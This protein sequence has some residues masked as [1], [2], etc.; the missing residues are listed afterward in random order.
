MLPPQRMALVPPF[1]MTD[2]EVRTLLSPLRNSISVALYSHGNPF[3][4]GAIIRVA[5][6]FLVR[7]IYIVGREPSYAKGSMGMHR[8]ETIR[9]MDD[10]EAFL[11]AVGSRPLWAVEKDHAT[12]SLFDDEPF[13]HDVVLLFGSERA[14]LPAGMLARAQQVL[15]V[16]M[17]GV[18]HSFPVSVAAGMVLNEWARR[19]YAPGTM[20]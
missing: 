6:S 13:P 9:V 16:P 4:V 17:Y 7:E 18:N 10:D 2:Q 3:S 11:E 20:L 8:F 14:G 12:R 1:D 19:R 15:G 5:H